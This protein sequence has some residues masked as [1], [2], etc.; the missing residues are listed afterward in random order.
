[1]ASPW[2]GM[3]ETLFVENNNVTRNKGHRAEW[4]KMFEEEARVK[5]IEKEEVREA[6]RRY[7]ETEVLD[8]LVEEG[9]FRVIDMQADG[10]KVYASNEDARSRHHAP[11][12][13]Q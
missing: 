1:M 13:R 2:R 9:I 12:K 6:W 7:I 10:R 11:K 4:E 8:K 5:G 3:A